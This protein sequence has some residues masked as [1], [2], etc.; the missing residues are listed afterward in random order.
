LLRYIVAHMDLQLKRNV[1]LSLAERKVRLSLR[2]RRI[3]RRLRR[4]ERGRIRQYHR[5]RQR[6][7]PYVVTGFP[8]DHRRRKA[9]SSTRA[10]RKHSLEANRV[11]GEKLDMRRQ[12]RWLGS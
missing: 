12:K 7:L 4:S 2:S 5:K 8:V 9:M 3:H 6:T 11:L 1:K 10:L